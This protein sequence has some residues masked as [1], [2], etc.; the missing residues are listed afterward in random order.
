MEQDPEKLKEYVSKN[1]KFW[2]WEPNKYYEVTFLG[3]NFTEFELKT[4]A[5]VP[6]VRYFLGFADGTE[7]PCDIRS[8]A[9]AGKMAVY[10]VGDLLRLRRNSIGAGKY[11]YEVNKIG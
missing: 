6:T 11:D 7:K 1:L 2:R 5:R 10:K 8:L 9:F 3:F 4:G